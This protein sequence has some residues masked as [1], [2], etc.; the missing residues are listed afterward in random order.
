MTSD[1]RDTREVHVRLDSPPASNVAEL[2]RQV[3]YY[4]QKVDELA[5]QVV[6]ADSVVSRTKRELKQRRDGFAL[7]SEL[8]RGVGADMSPHEIFDR[9]VATIQKM[10]KMDRTVVLAADGGQFRP[11][12]WAGFDDAA[13]RSFE[14]LQIAFDIEHSTGGVAVAPGASSPP[15]GSEAGRT[16]LVTKA[17]PDTERVARLRQQLGVPF[18]VCAPIVAGGRIAG[19]LLSGRMREAKPF[20]P[21]LDDGDVYTFQS[22]AG[23]LGSALHNAELF[24][25]VARMAQS[26]ARFVPHEFLEFLGRSSVVDVELG[27]Q[28]QL[29]MTV[30]F[31]D[32]RSFTSISERMTP[33]EN[34]DFINDYLKCV[35]PV[36]RANHGFID[37]YI[38]DAIMAL[39]PRADDGV[40]A[41]VGLMT[42]L[43]GFN[44]ERR[45]AGQPPI[46]IGAGLHTG[47]LMLGT[48][49][50]AQRLDTTVIS[51]AVNLASRVEGLTKMYGAAVLVTGNTLERLAGPAEFLHRRVDRVQVKGKTDPVDV[52]EVFGADHEPQRSLKVST[53]PDFDR[54]FAAY[55]GGN[56][57]V[58]A[59][60]YRE[61]IA[62][63]P[64][65]RAVELLLGRCEQ[66]I[67]AGAPPGWIGVTALDH[68]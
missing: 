2:Q 65:D 15:A 29:E 17:T 50:F 24:Q 51:D 27:D 6:R 10:L 32:I 52:I 46:A 40:R 25:H 38:G 31:S 37:K 41:A 68:K 55:C 42:A 60:A 3:A 16:L 5:G 7:L 9:A 64:H 20:F 63:N 48:V 59:A 8:Q 34:I 67:A 12:A 21:P 19:Y 54:A 35:G 66:Y 26:F 45:A 44:T 43:D 57:A 18:F 13:A 4:G 22:I 53:Q 56:F 30:L 23:F 61:I 36:V 39:F 49:G 1:G 14:Q 28:R 58:A 62:R 11:S 47:R 33:K